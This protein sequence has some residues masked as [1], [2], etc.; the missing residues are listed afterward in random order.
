MVTSSTRARL[1]GAHEIRGEEGG[2]G[3]NTIFRT[4]KLQEAKINIFTKNINV[5]V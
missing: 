1:W 4:R 2:G 3:E 5:K